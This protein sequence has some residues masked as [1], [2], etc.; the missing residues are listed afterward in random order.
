MGDRCILVGSHDEQIHT[1][2][3]KLVDLCDLLLAVVVGR[4]QTHFYGV[5][6]ILA[7]FQFAVELV[8]P[9]VD[10]ALRNT[11]D[12][13]AGLL[14]AGGEQRQKQQKVYQFLHHVIAS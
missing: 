8:S 9:D 3:Y 12:K 10:A 7:C 6:E 11:D 5:V 13:L 4:S 2:V 14:L 1:I